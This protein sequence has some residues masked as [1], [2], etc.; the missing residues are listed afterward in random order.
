MLCNDN[1]DGSDF[2]TRFVA[3]AVVV[4]VF[5][6]DDE[7]QYNDPKNHDVDAEYID[8]DNDSQDDD[9][10]AADDEGQEEEDEYHDDFDNGDAIDH[11]D[12]YYDDNHQ[13]DDD[14]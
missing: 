7:G 9:D 12:Y 1:A 3:V 8:G 13:H 10:A 14:S 2:D 4:G 11:D 5:D 6:D